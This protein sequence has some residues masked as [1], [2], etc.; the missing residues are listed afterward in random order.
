MKCKPTAGL[1]NADAKHLL[2]LAQALI[3]RRPGQAAALSCL[4]LVAAG[5]QV[6]GQ[7]GDQ[8]GAGPL[9]VAQQRAKLTLGE[10][11]NPSILPQL[12]K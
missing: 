1:V 6:G 8:V 2:D 3:Q 5:L 11:L 7:D 12:M 10:L 4:G 9:V